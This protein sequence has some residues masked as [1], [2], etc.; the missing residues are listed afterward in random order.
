MRIAAQVFVLFA[1]SAV[2]SAA[3]ASSVSKKQQEHRRYAA[4]SCSAVKPLFT[5]KSI[6]DPPDHSIEGPLLSRLCP[7][8]NGSSTCCTSRME[9]QLKALAKRE[10]QQAL[11]KN[12]HAIQAVLTTTSH[13][14]LD[15][16]IVL[17]R[18]SENHT[19]EVFSQVFQR[20]APEARVHIQQLFAEVRRVLANPGPTSF[21]NDSSADLE[22]ASLH[23]TVT[24]FFHQLFPLVYRHSVIH[25]NVD[26]TNEYSICLQNSIEKLRPFGDIP[27]SMGFSV[28]RAVRSIHDFLRALNLGT[29]A[30]EV[31]ESAWEKTDECSTA[32]LRMNY[33]S[34]CSGYTETKPCAGYCQNVLRGCLAP[35]TE[36]DASWNGYVDSLNEHAASSYAPNGLVKA[37]K[38]IVALETQIA[39]AVMQ[40]MVDGPSLEKRVKSAC[41]PVQLQES[42]GKHHQHK[43]PHSPA[44][45]IASAKKDTKYELETQLS[46]LA[47]QVLGSLIHSKGFFTA[48]SDSICAQDNFA[49]TEAVA[50]CWNGIKIAPYTKTVVSVGL[51]AQKYNPELPWNGKPTDLRIIQMSDRLRQVRRA[52]LGQMS[53]LP[54]ADNQMLEDGSGSGGIESRPGGGGPDDEDNWNGGSGSGDGTDRDAGE[55]PSTRL[56]NSKQH[57]PSGGGG[58]AATTTGGCALVSAASWAISLSFATMLV[59]AQH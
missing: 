8:V 26:I 20:L 15:K 51:G 45:S 54:E 35:L 10:L 34:W 59:L 36:L 48:L 3:R 31:A 1:L 22:E 28:A 30:L 40:A 53:A 38:A 25:T 47:K 5:A 18:R 4:S 58:G 43:P 56:P 12:S 55:H 23:D 21:L 42:G 19:L 33:C 16:I 17:S 7:K 6:S 29:E 50:D 32:L 49:E 46:N 37:E 27:K 44:P 9:H 57:S 24:N 52:L 39:D 13:Q 11:K 2:F 41:G 14:Y